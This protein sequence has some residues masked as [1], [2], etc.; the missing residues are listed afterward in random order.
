[1]DAVLG[2]AR[3]Q[4]WP[5]AQIHYEFF[6]ADAGP[7]AGDSAFEVMLASSGRVIRVAA[8]RSVAQALA[9]AGVSIPTSCAQGVCGT[10]LTRVIE[11]E[12]EHRDLYLTPE[13]QAAND[14]FLPCCSRARSGRLVLDL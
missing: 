4:G 11:G 10:C 3:A 14:Q 7:V 8:D 12:P 13:E 6:A 2:S 9:A 1:M 5:E